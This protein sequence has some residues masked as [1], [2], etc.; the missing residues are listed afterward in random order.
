MAIVAAAGATSVDSIYSG[1]DPA[2]YT[3]IANGLPKA[4]L[5]L[6]KS[7]APLLKKYSASNLDAF[8]T[9][10]AADHTGMDAVLDAINV[11][12]SGRNV[13]VTNKVSGTVLMDGQAAD[14]S[15]VVT[16]ADWTAQDEI[17]RA[18]V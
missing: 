14:L 12:Y 7:L 3:A 1:T 15:H 4:I 9:T 17:G 13:T 5:D 18:H 8:T 16:A 2:R 11:T 10:F 6:K